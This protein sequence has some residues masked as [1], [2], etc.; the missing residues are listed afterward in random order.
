MP[1]TIVNDDHHVSGKR[2][3]RKEATKKNKQHKKQS[4]PVLDVQIFKIKPRK[5]MSYLYAFVENPWENTKNNEKSNKN[6]IE[7]WR[8]Q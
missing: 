4:Q 2:K 8:K 7:I 5:K 6:F 3:L 1:E